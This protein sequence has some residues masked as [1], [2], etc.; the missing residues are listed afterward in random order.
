[1]PDILED[2]N[3]FPISEHDFEEALAFA[4][5]AYEDVGYTEEV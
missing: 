4:Q 2:Y 3:D 1:M 5:T